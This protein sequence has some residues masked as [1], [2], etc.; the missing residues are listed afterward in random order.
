MEPVTTLQHA[1]LLVPSRARWQQRA[2][3]IPQLGL[4]NHAFAGA[5]LAEQLGGG[6]PCKLGS[7]LQQL[8]HLSFIQPI[9]RGLCAVRSSSSLLR[10]E[11]F[12]NH[13]LMF[14]VQLQQDTSLVRMRLQQLHP[15]HV[16]PR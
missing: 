2:C 3:H 4:A 13:L 7:Q 8:L 15:D 1:G 12:L 9:C 11:Q 10:A 5:P 16:R 14:V 6:E